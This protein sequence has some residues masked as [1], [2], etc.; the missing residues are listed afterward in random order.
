MSELFDVFEVFE[1]IKRAC[2][3]RRGVEI[4][5]DKAVLVKIFKNEMCMKPDPSAEVARKEAT[6]RTGFLAPFGLLPGEA[7]DHGDYFSVPC[8]F[9]FDDRY[10]AESKFVI[11]LGLELL[12]RQGHE[13]IIQEWRD[14]EK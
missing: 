1:D 8:Y 13:Q 2:Y 6:C 14:K 5:N 11:K 7:Q 10:Q 12:K 9:S 4:Q 3:E